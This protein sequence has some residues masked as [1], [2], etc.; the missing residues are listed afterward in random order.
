MVLDFV[1]CDE[2]MEAVATYLKNK[3]NSIDSYMER[4]IGLMCEIRDEGIKAGKVNTAIGQY[5]LYAEDIKGQLT[6]ISNMIK[7][8]LGEFV[9]EVDV[10]DSY[11]YEEE[12]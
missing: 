1:L 12:A 11:V 10:I 3:G 4:Y 8:R 7:G 2:S 9:E 6:D 5:I